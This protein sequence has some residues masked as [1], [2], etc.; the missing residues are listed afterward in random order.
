[1]PDPTWLPKVLRDAGLRCDEFPGAYDRGH[2]DFGEIWGVVAHHT[3][4]FGETPNG[5]ANHPSLGLAS[6]LYLSRDGVYTFVGA[7]I[8]WHAGTGSWP[9]LPA[10]DANRLTIGIEAANDGGGTPG[11]PHHIPWTDQQYKA[12]VRGV[13]AILNRLGQPASHVIG[14]KEWAAV[15]G[16]WDPGGIN[17]EIFRRDVATQQ[18]DLKGAVP[19]APVRNEIDFY[20]TQAGHA[21][22]GKRLTIGEVNVG[23]DGRGRAAE[24]DNAIVYWSASTG[25]RAVPRADRSMPAGTSG[26][27]EEYQR[28]G[29]TGGALGFPVREFARL[30]AKDAA[31][32][33]VQ[34]FEGGV[35]YRR[36]G[37][38]QGAVVLGAIGA[39]WGADGYEQGPLGYPLN[40]EQPTSDGGRVQQFERGTLTWHP[41]GVTRQLTKEA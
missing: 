1:M 12:Y 26:L 10:N 8:A 9:G 38:P 31:S 17:M 13:A 7:G 25:T 4:S 18:A 16:K 36:D 14:H 21:W 6:Q 29:G 27:L 28:R 22:I 24:F 2:G 40:D 34:A 19:P 37:D 20:A 30:T 33:A 5:I 41:S 32:G 35:L 15:Q 3:G 39:R 23:K 11:K